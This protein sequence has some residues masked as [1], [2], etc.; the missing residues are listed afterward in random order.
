MGSPIDSRVTCLKFDEEFLRCLIWPLLQALK[1]LRPMIYEP[2][3]AGA[4]SARFFADAAVFERAD[5]DTSSARIRTPDLHA[6][7]QASHL[8]WMKS[9]WKLN[10]EFLE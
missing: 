8:P 6:L 3:R 7:H 5:Y 1:H 4:A 9:S 2:L 10:A